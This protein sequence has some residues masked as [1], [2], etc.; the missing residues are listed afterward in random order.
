MKIVGRIADVLVDH[1]RIAIVVML[2][3]TVGVGAGAPMVDQTSSLDQF[4]SDSPAGE[5]LDF[6]EANFA[7]QNG[8]TTTAQ[9]IV[10]D[11]DVLSKSAMLDVL[12]FQQA[13]RDNET[14]NDTLAESDAIL[15]VPN[16]VATAA[17]RQDQATEL[18][19]RGS[20]L[21]ANRSR[22]KAASRDL[23]NRTDELNA[24]AA[25]LRGSMTQLREN[26]EAP[27]EPA[28][29]AVDANTTVDLGQRHLETFRLA[30]QQLRVVTSQEEAEAAYTLGTRGVL[31]AEYEAVERRGQDLQEWAEALAERGKT[32]E[33]DR[34]ALQ[35]APAPTLAEQRGQLDSMNE[36]QVES[37][38]RTVLSDDGDGGDSGTAGGVLALMPSQGYD[39]GTAQANATMLVLTQATEGDT[40]SPVGVS[41]RIID[42]QLAIADVA[43]AQSGSLDYL[44]FGGGLITHE[45][46]ASMADSMTIVAPLALLFV[47]LALAIGYR[48]VLDIVLGLFGIGAVLAWTFGFMGWADIAFNQLFVAV[49]VL[50]IG[51]SIDYA[52]HI[53]MRHREERLG[54]SEGG[55][56]E[57]S[58]PAAH[59]EGGPAGHEGGARGSMRVALGGVGI[60]LVWVTAT[61]VIG[62]LSNLTSPVPPIREFGIVSSVGI[63]AALLV[64]GALVPALKV[65][66]DEL[67]EGWGFDRRKRAIGTGGGWAS[68]ALSVGA[69]AARK[70]PYVVIALA[71]LVT[72][73]GGY[74]GTQVSTAF[75]QSDF[76]AEDPPDWM[77]EL[78]EPFAP[79]EYSA[80]AN[81]AYV[82]DNF[83]REDSRAQILIEGDLASADA[84]ERIADAQT[85]AADKGVTKDI[86]GGEAAIQSPLTVME[87]VAATNETVAATVEAADTDGNGVPDANLTAVYGTLFEVA[88]DRA[89]SYI[90]RDGSD[91][92]AARIVVGVDGNAAGGAITDQMQAVAASIDGGGFEVTA[93][94]TPILNSI[95]QDQLLDTVIQSLLITIVAVFVFLMLAYRLTEGSATLG[96]VT[97]TPVVLSVA[98]ILGTMYLVDIPFN[99]MTGM[100]TSLTVGL[101]VAYSIHLSERYNQELERQRAVWPALRTAVTGTGGALVGSA[102]TTVGG[103]GVLVFAILPPLQQFGL[104][105][106]LTIVYALL[107]SVLV[108]PSLLVVWTRYVGPEWARDDLRDEEA[109]AAG[110]APGGPL[111]A[112]EGTPERGQ[113]GESA[114]ETA[115]P[116]EST[117]ETAKPN[118]STPETTQPRE[119]TPEATQHAEG[120]GEEPPVTGAGANSGAVAAGEPLPDSKHE[121]T[122]ASTPT[123]GTARVEGERPAPARAID[124]TRVLPGRGVGVG[125]AADA[126]AGRI[127][128][129]ETVSEGRI[130][131]TA[132]D[133]EPID[134]A[135]QGDTVYVVWDLPLRTDVRVSY[136]IAVPETTSDGDVLTVEGTLA[137]ED[138]PRQVG[139]GKE[140]QVETDLLSGIR[141]RGSVTADDLR[142]ADAHLH[143]GAIDR[144]AFDGLY[145]AWLAGGSLDKDEGGEEG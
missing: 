30:V 92:T 70:T 61:T 38:V 124:H 125:V 141:R 74:G 84:L 52:I 138:G 71:L 143:A 137:S 122:A 59:E 34:K 40:A 136:R 11:G 23:Q 24:T 89:G 93:T 131:V 16:V 76:L 78:P 44:V 8:D 118:E 56:T 67:L 31:Q 135:E 22:L 27:V 128:L 47:L 127:V 7:G 130:R 6:V 51:L 35:S 32:L 96:A 142:S 2:L 101:G 81:L 13:V 69:T 45:I 114:P 46:D 4:Q 3:L 75:D 66:L 95:V 20:D 80:K 77:K 48:D 36:S 21:Q 18:Q 106:G 29:R 140:L 104:I 73:A 91:Y 145:E 62:F 99:V 64:F 9:I 63:V 133:P 97:L 60:A 123:A 98:W 39:P 111:Q 112:D 144:A 41:D 50:L 57:E 17:I 110:E 33:D 55:T 14:V 54:E 120:D 37:V 82:N 108:L 102:A 25:R 26:P 19:Q 49:P 115:K 15:G 113:P 117:P 43:D 86:A 65:E 83:L 10:R 121:A 5:K 126:P 72:V 100:I 42:A 68:R 109:A 103:F 107:G 132:V 119:S 134:V 94:G 129:E 28:F 116:N 58:G 87:S 85:E 12:D 88:P 105:T 53:F 79:G 1:S 139:G 90:L